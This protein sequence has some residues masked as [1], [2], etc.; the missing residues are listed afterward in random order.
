MISLT[1]LLVALI[2]TSGNFGTS[3]SNDDK[4]DKDKDNDINIYDGD[5][6]NEDM[7]YAYISTNDDHLC[8]SIFLV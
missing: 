3:V 4:S 7:K 1:I 8:L 2:S 6:I 5:D